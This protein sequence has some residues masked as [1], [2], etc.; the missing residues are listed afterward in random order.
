[1][2]QII[3]LA[4]RPW[5]G[6]RPAP[7]RPPACAP[8]T[9]AEVGRHPLSLDFPR[10]PPPPPPCDTLVT[11]GVALSRKG[12]CRLTRSDRSGCQHRRDPAQRRSR[13]PG[14]GSGARLRRSVPGARAAGCR[15]AGTRTSPYR[16]GRRLR[17]AERPRGH[18][19]PPARP[20]PSDGNRLRARTAERPRELSRGGPRRRPRA[21][22]RE[23]RRREPAPSCASSWPSSAG[24][25]K[26]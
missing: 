11:V 26:E 9:A 23:H 12:R 16:P 20:R 1:M 25:F 22:P 2:V 8:P 18:P 15:L 17:Q 6:L 24:P 13:D 3:D 21:G 4:R 5:E 14:Q 10:G 19:L 7:T